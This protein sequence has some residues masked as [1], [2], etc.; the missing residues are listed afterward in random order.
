VSVA[1]RSPVIQAA[2]RPCIDSTNLIASQT[3]T[4]PISSTGKRTLRYDG[5]RRARMGMY[6]KD[7]SD[8]R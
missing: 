4:P 7:F 1:M 6:S 2:R 3:V 5:A 8:P